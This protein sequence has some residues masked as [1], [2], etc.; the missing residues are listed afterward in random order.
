VANF[1]AVLA[2]PAD[3]LDGSATCS[4][5]VVVLAMA[6][7]FTNFSPS[8]TCS[9][10][11]AA[12]RTCGLTATRTI[13]TRMTAIAAAAVVFKKLFIS[14]S[15]ARGRVIFSL[16]PRPGAA[17]FDDARPFNKGNPASD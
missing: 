2:I 17:S 15:C 1:V 16:E 13:A 14:L 8:R 9:P 10:L 7:S 3:M 5:P 11:T 6:P 12:A 4:T